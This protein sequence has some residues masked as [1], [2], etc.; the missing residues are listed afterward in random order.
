M[1]NL[2]YKLFFW[3]ILTVAFLEGLWV[4]NTVNFENKISMGAFSFNDSDDRLITAQGSW[5]STTQ[6][7]YPLSTAKIECWK[8]FGHCWIADATIMDFE[9]YTL[10]SPLSK[11][12]KHSNL[13]VG[14]NLKEIA[15]WN[16]DFIETK[17]YVPLSGCVEEIYRLD[18]RSKVV[19]YT[20]NTI[21][22]TDTC[23]SVSKESIVSKL[24]DGFER[25][26]IY[27]Q[28]SK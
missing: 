25:L 13:Y 18:R 9:E 19:T 28:L 21:K 2:N 1:K 20:G 3:I 12:F 5:I 15:V 24:G 27:K 7:A 26:R 17:P 10:P 22:T 8:E 14:L 4:F 23:D 16:D 11:I 6:L